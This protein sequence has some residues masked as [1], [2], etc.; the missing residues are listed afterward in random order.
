MKQYV[1]ILIIAGMLM[2]GPIRAQSWSEMNASK[3][4]SFE[5]FND[6]KIG[7]LIHWG[8]SSIPGGVWKGRT[9][10]KASKENR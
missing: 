5:W 1:I 6:A 2:T 8:I 9:A 7:M 3:T 10:G 4:E